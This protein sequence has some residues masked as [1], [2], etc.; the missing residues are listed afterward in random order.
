M[1]YG[2]ASFLY[3]REGWEPNWKKDRP[4]LRAPGS[5]AL[6]AWMAT[7]LRVQLVNTLVPYCI[8]P[9]VVREMR[10]PLNRTHNQ[11]HPFYRAVGDSR[12]RYRQAARA[13]S[14]R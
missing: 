4:V 8:E 9:E 12:E 6:S 5:D 7:N 3:T 1:R 13:A 14:T 11:T 2:L 10:P